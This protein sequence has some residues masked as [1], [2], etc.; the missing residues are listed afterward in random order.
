M[1]AAVLKDIE[2][3]RYLTVTQLRHKYCE[4]FGE[5]TR[6]N[7]KEFLF[8]RI[9]WRLQ[10]RAEGDL[11]ERARR[12]ALEIA[13]D[14]DLRVRAPLAYVPGKSA[15][16]R[17]AQ[18]HSLAGKRDPRVPLAGT[19]LAREFQGQSII[20]KVREDGFEYDGAV[21]R[22]LTAIACKV[23]GTRWNGYTFFGL[24]TPKRKQHAQKN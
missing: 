23:A 21:Y 5:E 6:S 18:I 15:D 17:R 4:V 14:A 24:D 8:R 20:V 3:L 10:A 2:S 19:L 7:H 9:A 11:S 16:I 1:E 22:S 13:D 12:R